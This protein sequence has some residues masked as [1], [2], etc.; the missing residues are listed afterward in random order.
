MSIP[1]ILLPFFV[2]VALI[3]GLML[4]MG[5]RRLGSLSRGDA[6][7]EDIALGQKTW[8]RDAQLAANAFENQFE[9]PMLFLLLAPLAILT[10]KSDI[11]FVILA[12]VFVLLRAAHAAV[13]VTSNDVR[14]RF[15][16]FAAGA[17]VLLLMWILFAAQILLR[18]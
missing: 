12:W 7:V 9:L 17:L 2:Q 14:L 1:F 11:P 5:S 18:F 8:P 16:I 13:H 15:Q 10:R 3:F 4:L 6:R